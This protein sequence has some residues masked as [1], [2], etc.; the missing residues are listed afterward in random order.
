MHHLLI[1][2]HFFWSA[3]TTDDDFLSVSLCL[4]VCCLM[5]F[6]KERSLFRAKWDWTYLMA[7]FTDVAK[8]EKASCPPRTWQADERPLPSISLALCN[9]TPTITPHYYSYYLLGASVQHTNNEVHSC[10]HLGP[11]ERLSSSQS[12]LYLYRRC[13]SSWRG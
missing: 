12:C 11:L 3:P 7:Y 5:A 8:R 9:N 1:Q 4:R 13:R 2:M 6:K 10:R